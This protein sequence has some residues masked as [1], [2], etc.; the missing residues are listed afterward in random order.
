MKKCLI[1]VDF[2]NDFVDG[3]LGFPDA[4]S[5]EPLILDKI[6]DYLGNGHDLLFTFD[7]HYEDYLE[8][9]EGIRLPIKHCIYGTLGHE[10]YGKVNDYRKH[11]KTVFN[12]VTF[13]S[14]ELGNYLKDCDYDEIELAGLVTNMCVISNAI[15]AKSALPEARIIVDSKASLSFDMELHHKTLDVLKGLQVDVI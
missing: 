8:T 6:K 7:T 13:G 4:K 12:K 15:I 3:A 11:A 14:L 10:L 1:I 2:Q 5:I 9:Q